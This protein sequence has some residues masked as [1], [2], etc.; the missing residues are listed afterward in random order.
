MADLL[1]GNTYATP[2]LDYLLRGQAMPTAPAAVH[3][4]YH[5]GDPTGNGQGGTSV[6]TSL[7]AAGRHASVAFSAASSRATA[8]TA[9]LSAT[10]VSG[11]TA[12]DWVTFWSHATNTAEADFIGALENATTRTTVAGVSEILAIGALDVTFP[13]NV[14]GAIIVGDTYAGPFLNYLL[15]GTAM[16]AAPAA[17]HVGFHL[18]TPGGDGQS[19]TAKTTD[20]TTARFA[21]TFSA[22]LTRA[23]SNSS[24][25]DVTAIAGGIGFNYLTIWS[26]ATNSAVGDFICAIPLSSTITTVLDGILRIAVADIAITFPVPA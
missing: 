16:P 11:G 13:N 1:V 22:A 7:R 25:H 10:P 4:G 12:F 9:E 3:M 21:A 26:H 18:N 2:F 19:G 20:I 23:I 8:N 15:R 14:S 17:W 5:S 6:T 24:S